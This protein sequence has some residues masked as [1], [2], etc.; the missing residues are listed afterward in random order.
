MQTH[1]NISNPTFIPREGALCSDI[2][3]SG[4]LT[5]VGEVKACEFGTSQDETGFTVNVFECDECGVEYHD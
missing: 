2:D 3:C 4:R 5:K 1:A